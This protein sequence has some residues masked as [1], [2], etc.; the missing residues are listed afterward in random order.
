MWEK[1]LKIIMKNI[2]KVR[3]EKDVTKPSNLSLSHRIIKSIQMI[4]SVGA[5]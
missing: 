2:E 1:S 5:R 4:A 3:K